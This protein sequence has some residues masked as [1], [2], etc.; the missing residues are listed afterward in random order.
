MYKVLAYGAPFLVLLALSPL[1]YGG[2]RLAVAGTLAAVALVVPS[3]IVATTTA[4]DDE[5]TTELLEPLSEASVP[6]GDV[7]SVPFADPWDQAW[8]FYYLRDHRLSVE[9]PSFILTGEGQRRDPAVPPSAGAVRR[10]ALARRHGRASS[11]P[12]MRSGSPDRLQLALSL[13]R[14]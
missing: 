6:V 5:R 12:E 11:A 13:P 1:V 14:A 7:I 9:Q 8:A 10:R 3:A 4:R 2:N